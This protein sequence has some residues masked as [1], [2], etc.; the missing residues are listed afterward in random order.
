MQIAGCNMETLVG[1]D[2]ALDT[3]KK[4]ILQ[5][6]RV[7]KGENSGDGTVPLW[8]ALLPAA[9]VYY[10]QEKHSDLPNNREVIRAALDLV[11]GEKP[12]LP[13]SLPEPKEG[14]L[15][16]SFDLPTTQTAEELEAKIR[17]GTAS[18][19]DLKQLYFAF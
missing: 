1:L 5:P 17:A 15:G 10:I 9:D 3:K 19:E 11:N 4:I 2:S 8:S 14:F 18:Q 12:A 7:E 16:I 6:K 13:V